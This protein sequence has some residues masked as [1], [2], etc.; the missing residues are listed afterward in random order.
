M[1]PLIF[2]KIN[3]KF[4]NFEATRIRRTLKNILESHEV[5]YS[6]S[7][8]DNSF[9]LVHFVSLED[10]AFLSNKLEKGR[11][12]KKVASLLSCEEDFYGKLLEENKNKDID[13]HCVVKK[14]DI[15]IINNL[16]MCFVPSNDAKNFLIN[17]GVTTDIEIFPLP[18]RISKYNLKNSVLS[19]AIYSYLRI[20][21]DV[22][23]AVATLH[24]K[25]VEAFKRLEYIVQRFPKIKFICVCRVDGGILM[26]RIAKQII[27]KRYRNLV[28]TTPL[29]EDL[30][31]SLLYNSLFYLNIGSTYGNDLESIESMASKTQIFSLTNSGFN[32]LLIDKK[33]CYLYNNI[34][35]LRVGI[36]QFLLGLIEP[37]VKSA[38]EFVKNI[39]IKDAGY[40]L[41]E[42]Y[43][44]V[45]KE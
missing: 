37:T 44:K 40:K 39:D 31:S 22:P 9:D 42:C 4:D 19:K 17:L 33:N 15:E 1:K 20:S 16:D 18:I 41:I 2:T 5:V 6:V 26:P 35:L 38:Y 43:K 28:L 45:L 10:V 24:Y 36:D 30:Y 23:L 14:S 32:D 21:E 34:D 29:S 8:L 11:T 25:D 12:F 7:E 27:K 3:P 13:L